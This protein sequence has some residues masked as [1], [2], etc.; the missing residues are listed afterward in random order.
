L[1][2]EYLASCLST[3]CA[4]DPAIVMPSSRSSSPEVK[5]MGLLIV[6]FLPHKCELIN[7]TFFHLTQP[8]VFCYSTS[9]YSKTLSFQAW[10]CWHSSLCLLE[11]QCFLLV[12]SLH[13]AH[14][15]QRHM[16]CKSSSNDPVWRCHLFLARTLTHIN[17]DFF[18]RDR[19]APG[20]ECVKEKHLVAGV[21]PGVLTWTP[22]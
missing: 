15:F 2:L 13:P 19:L 21:L 20:E 18:L 22:C 4:P 17:L 9:K 5:L 7:L 3:T 8:E 12:M 14:T 1:V 11:S 6:E 10:G 16:L